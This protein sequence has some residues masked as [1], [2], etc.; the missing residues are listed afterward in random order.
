[1]HATLEAA[2]YQYLILLVGYSFI[3]CGTIAQHVYS[4]DDSFSIR[5]V[6]TSRCLQGEDRRVGVARCT[7]FD[8]QRWKWGSGHRLFHVATGRCLGLE[9][10]SKTLALLSCDSAGDMLWWRCSGGIIHTASQLS[11]S[12]INDAVAVKKGFGDQ[13]MRDNTSENICQ[14]PYQVLYSTMGNSFGAACEFPFYYN[15]SWHHGCLSHGQEEDL[16]WCPTTGNYHADQKW[17]YCLSPEQS[18][19]ILWEN[20][21]SGTCYQY[22]LQAALSWREARASCRNQGGDL[23]SVS[24]PKELASVSAPANVSL[25]EQMWT[26]LNQLDMSQ[27]WQWSD[28]TP[29]NFVKWDDGMPLTSI[30][31][32]ADCAVMTPRG[33]WRSEAC[34]MRL[35]YICKKPLKRTQP[36]PAAPPLDKT[37]S[38]EPNWKPWDDFCI[39][40]VK[41]EPQTMT[42]A[43]QYCERSGADLLS[44]HSLSDVEALSTELHTGGVFE[45]WTGLRS[46]ASP[47]LFS[48]TDRSPVSFTYWSRDQPQF[49]DE[50]KPACVSYF[51]ESHLWQVTQCDVKLPFVCKKKGEIKESTEKAGC[52][53]DGEWK[54]HGNA[55]YKVDTNDVLFKDRCDLTITNRFEQMFI[56]TLIKEHV[57]PESK[58]FW[59]GL[60]NVNDTGEFQWITKNGRHKDMTYSNWNAFEPALASGCV[61]ISTKALGKWEVKDCN[62]FKAGSVCK[63]DIG[64]QEEPEPDLSLPCPSGWTSRPYFQYCYKVF[65]KVRLTRKRSWEEAERFCKALGAHLVSFSH[66]HDMGTIQAIMKDSISQDQDRYFWSGLNR[67]S[68]TSENSW[69]WSNGRPV[70]IF[71]KEL[72]EDDEFN[73]DCAAFKIRRR[74]SLDPEPYYYHWMFN[75]YRYHYREEPAYLT[76]FH[77]DAQLEWVCQIPR[78]KSET[79]PEWY[80]PRGHHETSIFVG[81]REF[82]FVDDVKLTYEEAGEY[83]WNNGSKL[84]IPTSYDIMRQ[85]AKKI[86]EISNNRWVDLFWWVDLKS[87]MHH[88]PSSFDFYHYHESYGRCSAIHPFRPPDFMRY[89]EKPLP[90]V[91]ER[92]NVTSV[93]NLDPEPHPAGMSCINGS[94]TFGDKCYTVIKPLY[95]SF[96]LASDYCQ[97]LKGTLPVIS[98]QLEQDFFTSLLPDQPMKFWLGLKLNKLT[99]WEWVD[100][101]PIKFMNF[102]PLLDG[103]YGP[104]RRNLLNPGG[105]ENCSYI[106]RDPHP[107][108]MGTWNYVPCTDYQ[109]VSIC[110]HYTDKPESVQVPQGQFKVGNHT[111]RIL[112]GNLTWSK[113]M[114]QCKELDMNLASV[115]ELIQQASL[116]V[117][118][119]RANMSLWI[120]LYSADNY[121]YRW[122]DNSHVTFSRWSPEATSGR[123]VYLDTD[124]FWKAM[125]CEA[126]LP[127]AICHIPQAVVTPEHK[128]PVKCPHVSGGP[129][130]I[131]FRNNCYTLGVG[132]SRWY[133]T[134]RTNVRQRC[135]KLDKNAEILTI[136][137]ETENKFVKEQLL[138]F[139]DL[140]QSVWLGLFKDENDNRWKWYDGT[141]V[142]YSNWPNGRPDVTGN[143]MVGLNLFGAWEVVT[144]SLFSQFKQRSIVVCKIDNDPKEQYRTS[145]EDLGTYGNLSYTIIQK[146]LTWFEA[147]R[148]CHKTGAHL[149]SIHDSTHDRHLEQISTVDGFPLWIGLSRQQMNGYM[150]YEWSDGSAYNYVPTEFLDF[151]DTTSSCVS[152][153]VNGSWIQ[154]DCQ[155]QQEGTICYM[156]N[157][158]RSDPQ[159]ISASH[160]CPEGNNASRW[161]EYRDHCYAFSMTFFNYSIYTMDSAKRM[162]Q[163][164]EAS[165]QLLTIQ[166]REENDFISKYLSENPVLTS[167]VWLGMDVDSNGEPVSWSDGS[168]LQFSNWDRTG[169]THTHLKERCAVLLPGKQGAWR[170]VGC[171]DTHSRIVCKMPSWSGRTNVVLAFF[172][173]IFITLVTSL[174]ILLYR[175]NRSRFFSTVRYQRQFDRAD[176]TSIVTQLE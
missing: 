153:S 104:L 17:G 132:S 145:L 26:G 33:F 32:E 115:T 121:N 23:L 66:L 128:S 96:E 171:K 46:E 113:A 19:D 48:W 144:E 6:S 21:G 130:W 2:M 73:R 13:W 87:G 164:L 160:R 163:S 70:S 63:K 103:Y 69:E 149:A 64:H 53:D 36:E 90:F 71:S 25:P 109:Y 101:S 38:C 122:T 45:V 94:L 15:G 31:R 22:N 124:G 81:G 114:E 60:Q 93:E 161:I 134:A 172:L 86:S 125:D 147:L 100:K 83:C 28:S 44:L 24:G 173:I 43:Q 99:G 165:S 105:M 166:D 42:E 123:C 110:Q 157:I 51:E 102:N 108:I 8:Q 9:A 62:L 159:P 88:F 77:C 127:G 133:D 11:L 79:I 20:P 82:W 67:R 27:G 65:D 168:S 119:S 148:E 18:C 89:C 56:N 137:D 76:P 85:I 34:S 175:R 54:R 140:A 111:Y 58:Y 1:M 10:D 59:T 40:L 141:N 57:T 170:L 55:C 61:A 131:P 154:R 174:L 14:R 84:A 12:V 136:R 138:P 155:S 158:E 98:S 68:A 156:N 120:G 37:T 146:K 95:L 135:K 169:E 16:S 78:G 3:Y 107:E 80:N 74:Q 151:E 118:A 92:M 30:L 7:S 106:I 35:P 143:F 142:Q 167:R 39:N 91:C 49:R 75:Y 126:E 162:C 41:E 4:G 176:C 29:L 97:S 129:I 52:P 139:K 116:S 5:H 117:T 112:Q 152:I 50:S 47:Y 150:T 72:Q